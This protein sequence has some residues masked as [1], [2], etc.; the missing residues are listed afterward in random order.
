LNGRE[1][2]TTLVSVTNSCVDKLLRVKTN[3]APPRPVKQGGVVF[4]GDAC[5]LEPA[6]NRNHVQRGVCR[7]GVLENRAAARPAIEDIYGGDLLHDRN[8]MTNLVIS[9][10]GQNGD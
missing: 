1:G 5:A 4:A 8:I 2:V 3:P 10:R 7:L 9:Q 6:V